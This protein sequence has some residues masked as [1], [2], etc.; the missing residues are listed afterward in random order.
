MSRLLNILFWSVIAAAFIGPGTVTT[1]ASAGHGFGLRLLWA[2]AFSTVA[3]LVLQEAA[4]RLTAVSG[5]DL[6]QALRQRYHGGL[7]G[8]AVLVVVLGAVVLGCASYEA[9]NILGAVVGAQLG[10]AVATP[11][12]VLAIGLGA[13]ALLWSGRPSL[14]ARLMGLLVAVMGA[15]FVITAVVL[16]P[17]LPELLRGL[18]MPALPAGSGVVVLALVGTTVV[19]YNLFLGSGLA[20]G[21][22]LGEMRSGLAVAVVLG[23]LISM[24]VVVVGT[25]VTGEFSFPQLAEVLDGRFPGGRWLLAV[26]L[27][28]AG[29]TSAVTAP[30]AAAI[31]ARSL[32]SDAEDPA[33]SPTSARF[34]GVWGLVLAVGLASG[35]SGVRPVPA[36]ILAQAFNGLL[37]PLVAV[38]LLVAVND[39]RLMGER[40]L[41]GPWANA[42]MA[43]VVWV[44]LVLGARQLAGAAG[45]VLALPPVSEEFLLALAAGFALLLAVPVARAV[46]RGRSSSVA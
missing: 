16:A 14:I 46:L 33:W 34:R 30:L 2:L 9:G 28:A 3:C 8:A 36:I 26:G 38:F 20:R 37:L 4:A 32:F 13:V 11:W 39:R 17:P 1:A 40:G 27:F 42:L 5:L 18:L 45:K 22:S 44:T 6:G 43:A 24:A 35:L 15:A 21:Q 19:P 25:V 10:V 12:L 29:L 31:T 41:N 7:G 23:G